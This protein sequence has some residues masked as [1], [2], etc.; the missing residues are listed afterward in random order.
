MF[1]IRSDFIAVFK[2]G[3]NINYNLQ[4]LKQLYTAYESAESPEKT[5]LIKPIIIEIMSIIEATLCDFHYRIKWYT[6]EGVQNLAEDLISQIRQKKIDDL[7]KY[8]ASA[9]SRAFFDIVH[10]DFYGDLDKLRKIR[11]RVHIQNEK[12]YLPINE[13]DAFTSENKDLAECALEVVFRTMLKKYPRPTSTNGHV[14]NFEI[15]W[16]ARYE[17]IIAS[18]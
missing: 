10:E 4:I 12:K 9:K 16:N 18:S 8:I 7:E 15:P 2:I 14:Q 1:V 17:T 5:F 13:I 6:R 3:D 11:N